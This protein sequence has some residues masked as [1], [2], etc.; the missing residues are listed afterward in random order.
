MQM[1]KFQFVKLDL[2]PGEKYLAIATVKYL[3]K[4]YLRFK[5]IPKKDGSDFFIASP[6]MKIDDKYVDGFS[7][8]SSSDNAECKDLIKSHYARMVNPSAQ[9]PVT[10]LVNYNNAP[11]QMDFLDACPF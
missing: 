2:T 1:I 8:D 5:I 10:P 4:I 3:D 6:A 11:D 7:L 9:P